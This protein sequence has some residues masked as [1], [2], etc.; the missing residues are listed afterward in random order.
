MS[1]KS[2]DIWLPTQIRK[3]DAGNLP[4][5]WRDVLD[6]SLPGWRSDLT[7]FRYHM[8]GDWSRDRLRAFLHE[9]FRALDAGE[10]TKAVIGQMDGAMAG[11]S[12]AESR[13]YWGYCQNKEGR[14]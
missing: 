5:G 9:K 14:S 3:H 13:D 10:L 2:I 4:Q 1:M 7:R 11:W 12:S 6:V 8:I